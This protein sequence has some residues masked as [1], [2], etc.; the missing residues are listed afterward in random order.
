MNGERQLYQ[1]TENREA[2]VLTPVFEED[3]TFMIKTLTDPRVG[4]SYILPENYDKSILEN[5]LNRFILLSSDPERYV[6][7][8][9]LNNTMVG[10][11][12]DTGIEKGRVELG[13]VVSPDYQNRGICSAAVGTA[14]RELFSMG[15]NSVYAG[16]F[17]ENIPSLRVMEKNG[18]KVMDKEDVIVYRGEEHICV[19]R[20]IR[21]EDYMV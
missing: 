4:K 19:Y 13:W 12:N 20:L 15:Y 3:R 5:I 18:M 11:I 7:A 17:Q 10:F 8:I 2:I 6:R 21:R 16:A 9:R 1:L 14:I